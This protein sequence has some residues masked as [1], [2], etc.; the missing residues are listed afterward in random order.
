M[1]LFSLFWPKA[2][3]DDASLGGAC[4][5]GKNHDLWGGAKHFYRFSRVFFEFFGRFFSGVCVF[6]DRVVLSFPT[7]FDKDTTR[8]PVDGKYFCF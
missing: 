1:S 8:N 3:E 6:F 2:Q 7:S 5:T 4:E